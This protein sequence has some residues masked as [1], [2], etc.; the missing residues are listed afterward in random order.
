M[1]ELYP[2]SNAPTEAILGMLL[3]SLAKKDTAVY[4]DIYPV[5]PEHPDEYTYEYTEV[6][7][8]D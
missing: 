8:G 1:S 5:D 2:I 4:I 7:D 6:K 3:L